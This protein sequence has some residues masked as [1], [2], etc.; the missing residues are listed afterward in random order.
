MAA[1]QKHGTVVSFDLNYR[2][3]LWAGIG[4]PDV[5]PGRQHPTGRATS[6]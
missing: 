4:G 6:T 1:A 3:S 5:R 2:P